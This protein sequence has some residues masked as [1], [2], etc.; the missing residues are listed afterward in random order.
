MTFPPDDWTQRPSPNAE[1]RSKKSF[2]TNA[3][4]NEGLPC[5]FPA[6]LPPLMDDDGKRVSVSTATEAWPIDD[7]VIN[8][9]SAIVVTEASHKDDH[10][11]WDNSIKVPLTAAL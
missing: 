4:A 2:R 6:D 11:K 5:H 7:H 3:T 9:E 1:S 10:G 8:R